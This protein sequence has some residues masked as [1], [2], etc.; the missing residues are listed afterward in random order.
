V[1]V[2]WFRKAAAAVNTH[3]DI[4]TELQ[5]ALSPSIR[6]VRKLEEQGT[7]ANG[8]ITGIHFFLNDSTTRKEFAVSVLGGD[9]AQRFGVRT[10]PNE[11][12]RL[13]LGMSVV[14][15]LDGNRGIVDWDA[16]ARAWGLEGQF[17][18][19]ESIR[20]PPAD[21]IVDTA[22]DARVQRHLKK[23]LPTQATIVSLR[24]CTV[25]GM[26]TLNWD[27]EL[28]LPDGRT[29]VSKRDEV[30]S[31]AQWDAA[32]GVVVPAV[33]DPKDAGRA[34]IDWPAFALARFDAVGFD[35]DP[36]PGSIAAEVEG[37]RDAHDAPAVMGANVAAP[38]AGDPATPVALDA[39]MR[40]WVDARK[41]GHMT[42][43]D[44]D[45]AL[46]DWNA[47]GMCTAAQVEAARAESP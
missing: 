44:F 43:K 38:P 19:Q 10:Q 12:H 27:V 45:Q 32:P 21:G 40:S 7:P 5:M 30:P 31:Y 4:A 29:A 36:P 47:A 24:R 42:Q 3:Y 35:D 33:T 26:P 11:A 22:L 1:R 25:M 9:A 28:R 16:M 8:V 41:G 37:A 46:D 20:K 23:W 6:R 34:S 2:A 18:S 39:T 17:L 14:A 15:R 13:R